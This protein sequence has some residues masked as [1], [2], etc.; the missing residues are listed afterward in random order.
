LPA[1]HYPP[2]VQNQHQIPGLAE[3]RVRKA[4]RH[5]KDV[6]PGATSTFQGLCKAGLSVTVSKIAAR[7]LNPDKEMRGLANQAA[8]GETKPVAAC[9]QRKRG[10]TLL[11]KTSVSNPSGNALRSSPGNRRRPQTAFPHFPCGSR[12]AL[13]KRMFPITAPRPGKLFLLHGW[14]ICECRRE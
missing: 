6:R 3:F 1:F 10:E 2:V 8:R 12:R 11:S 9:P 7:R 13:P 4:M 5:H 14:P